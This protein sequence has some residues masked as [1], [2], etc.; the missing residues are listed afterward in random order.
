MEITTSHI[1]YIY[2]YVSSV[3]RV[4]KYLINLS[5][6]KV[7]FHIFPEFVP[8]VVDSSKNDSSLGLPGALTVQ[9]A[10]EKAEVS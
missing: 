6:Y 4:K 10:I 5:I 8:V 3:L 9:N 2:M 7:L 1:S